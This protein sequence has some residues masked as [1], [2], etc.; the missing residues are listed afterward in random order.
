M[1]RE[2]N[3]LHI[4]ERRGLTVDTALWRPETGMS[5]ERKMW[6]DIK[7]SYQKPLKIWWSPVYHWFTSGDRYEFLQ[8][9][10]LKKQAPMKIQ[11][12]IVGWSR[13]PIGTNGSFST[14]H[15]KRQT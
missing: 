2:G 6:E 5:N 10:L 11:V 12:A 8:Y 15:I 13:Q 7:M 14:L 3:F 9:L 4:W 1:R